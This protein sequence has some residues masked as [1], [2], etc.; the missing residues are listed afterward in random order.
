LGESLAAAIKLDSAKSKPVNRNFI[1]T[2]SSQTKLAP[3]STN[4]VMVKTLK[5]NL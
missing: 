5:D 2:E 3:K 1:R 4:A